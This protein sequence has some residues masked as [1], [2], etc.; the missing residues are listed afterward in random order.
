VTPE[1]ENEILLKKLGVEGTRREF[2]ARFI[3]FYQK[4]FRIQSGAEPRIG[5]VKVSLTKEEAK[6][7]LVNGSPLLVFDELAL[8]WTLFQDILAQVVT[9]FA[10]YSDLLGELPR[11][12]KEMQ[13]HPSLLKEVAKTWFESTQ[14]ADTTIYADTHKY[15]L[16]EATMHASLKP[17]L[18]VQAKA[19]TGLVDQEYWRREYCPIC[20]GRPDLA[21]LDKERGSRWL[22]CSRCDTPWLYQRLQCPYCRTQNPDALYYFTD[23]TGLYRLYVCEQC[24][25]YIKALDLRCTSSDISLPLERILTLDMDRQAEEKGYHPG[26]SPAQVG[27]T[28]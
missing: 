2:P 19:F 4:L 27:T 8:D 21:F 16:F 15:L 26:H 3:E 14:L 18:I 28:E 5:Q 6:Q 24:H 25:K 22:V 23:A 17:F 11:N 7:R 12:L 10:E 20:G 9:L 1:T 13:P